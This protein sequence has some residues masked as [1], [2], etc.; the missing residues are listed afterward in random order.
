MKRF[1]EGLDRVGKGIA[2]GVT[3]AY[4]SIKKL[5]KDSGLNIIK[6][7]GTGIT[8]VTA[9]AQ[10]GM[11]DF[12]GAKLLKDVGNN[13]AYV[14]QKFGNAVNDLANKFTEF[15]ISLLA[16][17]GSFSE[18]YAYGYGIKVP[19][20][21]DNICCKPYGSSIAVGVSVG[22][23]GPLAGIADLVNGKPSGVSLN[24]VI[25]LVIGAVPGSAVNGGVRVGIGL[26]ASFGCSSGVAD[27]YVKLV[28]GAMGSAIIPSEGCIGGTGV[29]PGM[30]APNSFNEFGFDCPA[31]YA[32]PPACRAC[33]KC[34]F[35]YGVMVSIMCCN[36]YIISG[37][38]DCR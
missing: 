3:S 12:N 17:L 19:A 11:N 37:K 38:G 1:G 27:C 2:A 4:N 9:E 5:D 29:P 33:F 16:C 28:L 31:C 24:L 25:S 23:V 20:D 36:Y 7:T 10:K 6:H 34:S 8:T 15:L 26:A 30:K 14:A 21:I 32:T 13:V 18:G 35:G 22:G